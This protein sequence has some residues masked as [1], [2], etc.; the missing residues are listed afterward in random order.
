M[1]EG[2]ARRREEEGEKAEATCMPVVRT[3]GC[4]E[5]W[6]TAYTCVVSQGLERKLGKSTRVILRRTLT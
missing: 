4:L 3:K 5:A 1:K 2:T 6:R